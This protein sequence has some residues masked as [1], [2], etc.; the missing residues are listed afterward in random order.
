[1][2]GSTVPANRFANAVPG[3]CHGLLPSLRLLFVSVMLAV[4]SP[5]SDC[6]TGN[7]TADWNMAVRAFSRGDYAEAVT[8]FMKAEK[9]FQDVPSVHYYLG[10]SLYQLARYDESLSY[11]KASSSA[12]PD[13]MDHVYHYFVGA[14]YYR[15]KLYRL[16]ALEMNTVLKGHPDS[17]VA[18]KAREALS[19]IRALPSD[20]ASA[21]Q[22]YM[23]AA[24][25]GLERGDAAWAADYAR[26]A[27]LCAAERQDVRILVAEVRLA[28]GMPLDALRYV[29]G[30]SSPEALAFVRGILSED[31]PA[32]MLAVD[33]IDGLAEDSPGAARSRIMEI[34]AGMKTSGDRVG[35]ALLAAEIHARWP[36]SDEAVAVEKMLEDLE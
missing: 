33:V 27:F 30:L 13:F 2:I 9:T 3:P 14:I 32:V 1:M 36:A 4:F 23:A 34:A 19:N 15:K 26:E 16:A 31:D 24:R 5:A 21:V 8:C 6:E 7:P 20:N 17:R 12:E 10:L 28:Q 25:R 22:W 29:R 18:A 11:F 35:L